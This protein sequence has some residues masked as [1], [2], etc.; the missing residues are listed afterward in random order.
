MPPISYIQAKSDTLVPPGRKSQQ[1]D[2][3]HT[4]VKGEQRGIVGAPL[5]E[6]AREME[7]QQRDRFLQH[8]QDMK[9]SSTHCNL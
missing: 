4:P 5:A 1:G 6:Q 9:H 7:E 3:L 8:C 2:R